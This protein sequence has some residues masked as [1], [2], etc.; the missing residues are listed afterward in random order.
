MDEVVRNDIENNQGQGKCYQPSQRP[1]LMTLTE[2][3][4]ILGVTKTE[5]NNRFIIPCFD[6]SN[7][8]HII[9]GMH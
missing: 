3:L 8:K 7:D 6:E 2:T 4:I 1:W 9:T 5:S